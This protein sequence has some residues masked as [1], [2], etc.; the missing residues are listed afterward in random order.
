MGSWPCTRMR[1]LGQIVGQPGGE[2]RLVAA[3]T[4]TAKEQLDVRFVVLRTSLVAV[5]DIPDH[6][7][8]GLAEADRGSGGF[9]LGGLGTEVTGSRGGLRAATIS[10]LVQTDRR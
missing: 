2:R 5:L 4:N 6:R 9:Q 10:G 3:A 7:S 1:R 8:V